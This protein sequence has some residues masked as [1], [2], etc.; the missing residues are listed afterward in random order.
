MTPGHQYLI[1]VLLRKYKGT[2]TAAAENGV[3]RTVVFKLIQLKY[4][5]TFFVTHIAFC[6]ASVR[7]RRHDRGAHP[8]LSSRAPDCRGGHP[9]LN[10][11]RHHLRDPSR[12]CLLCRIPS[13]DLHQLHVG[14]EL[15][16]RG[17]VQIV[18]GFGLIHV[19]FSLSRCFCLPR[20][21]TVGPI[22]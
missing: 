20:R 4:Q 22:A 14:P 3:A 10:L 16:L 7:H 18:R 11:H 5:P 17:I 21:P 9:R 13:W 1:H 2:G 6:H 15:G 8:D 12:A 19:F